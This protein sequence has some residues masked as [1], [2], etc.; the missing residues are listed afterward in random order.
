MARST[1]DVPVV[2]W[3]PLIGVSSAIGCG[4]VIEAMVLRA[5][6]V[7]EL[8]LICDGIV[9]ALT[10]SRDWLVSDHG[11]SLADAVKL[12]ERDRTSMLI[13]GFG[14]VERAL[15]TIAKVNAKA[16]SV[17]IV[18][19]IPEGAE[20]SVQRL[21]RAGVKG[22]VS[23]K[24]NSLELLRCVGMLQDGGNYVSPGLAA[25]LLCQ[26]IFRVRPPEP[27]PSHPSL[28]TRELEILQLVAAGESNKAIARHL[29][30]SEKSVKRYMTHI[31]QKIQVR[32]RL[33]AAL[34]LE[35]NAMVAA[36]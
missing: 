11:T 6:V 3:L 20:A 5:V 2:V 16:G 4:K 24:T 17:N 18:C 13:F 10:A 31:M 35:E 19:L 8:P 33:Q 21:L 14:D 27:K 9:A 36:Q 26:S 1:A 29:E 22:C 34:Y 23:R 32:N 15:D 28:T 30:L 25:H 7:D 12:V